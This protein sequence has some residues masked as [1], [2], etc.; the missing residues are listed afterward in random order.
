MVP[1]EEVLNNADARPTRMLLGEDAE[2]GLSM[3]HP[4]DI[5]FL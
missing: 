1:V 3:Q 4:I 2:E 5:A